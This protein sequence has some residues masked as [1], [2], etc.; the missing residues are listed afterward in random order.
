MCNVYNKFEDKQKLLNSL[1]YTSLES[2]FHLKGEEVVFDRHK[3]NICSQK[4]KL[5]VLIRRLCIW[6]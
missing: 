4:K 5:S 3:K 2:L 1:N 6:L